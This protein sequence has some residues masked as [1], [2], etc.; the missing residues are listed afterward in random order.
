MASITAGDPLIEV[1]SEMHS[2]DCANKSGDYNL[3]CMC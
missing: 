1:F 2:L 3:A